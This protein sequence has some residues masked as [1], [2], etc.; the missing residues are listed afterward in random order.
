MTAGTLHLVASVGGR[1]VLFRAGQV[2]AVI[3]VAEVVPTPRAVAGVCGLTALRSRVV[4]VIDTWRVLGL[5]APSS[6]GGSAGRRRRAVITRMDGHLYAVPVDRLE[7]AATFVVAPLAPGIV[8]GECWAAVADG[9]AIR[10]G[11]PLIAI[12]LARLVARVR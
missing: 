11:E 8:T 9:G 1:G 12:D 5:P 3:D 2:E 6:H 10:D 4:T 7:D